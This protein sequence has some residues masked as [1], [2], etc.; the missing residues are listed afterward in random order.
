MI[1]LYQYEVSPFCD[2]VRRILHYKKR[3]YEV[4][5]ISMLR[6]MTGAVG[7]LHHRNKL[8][9]LEHHGNWIPDSTEISLYLEE[10][11]PLPALIPATED[12]RAQVLMLED[13]ADEA[14]CF[15]A[16]YCHSLL[17]VSD[18]EELEVLLKQDSAPVRRLVKR[19]MP[20]MMKHLLRIQGIGRRPDM[21]VENTLT[22]LCAAL[23]QLCEDGEWLVGNQLT[24]ADISVFSQLRRIAGTPLGQQIISNHSALTAWMERV[25]QATT[26]PVA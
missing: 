14:L 1:K 25:N 22:E 3:A 20:K 16:V 5:N 26:A 8:P 13:W 24:L 10:I 2:K 11:Q 23:A 6:A 15:Y 17:D 18:N 12:A 21:E 19:I 9:V 7:R 4:E